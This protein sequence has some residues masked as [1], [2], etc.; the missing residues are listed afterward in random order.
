MAFRVEHGIDFNCAL[1]AFLW[2]NNI[3]RFNVPTNWTDEL[4]ERVAAYPVAELYGS[5]PQTLTGGGRAAK[6]LPAV[7]PNDAAAH[8]ARVRNGGISFDY[9]LNAACFG[10]RETEPAFRKALHGHIQWA[11]DLGVEIIT[12]A[13][14]FLLEFIKTHFPALKVKLSIFTHVTSPAMATI[15]AIRVRCSAAV[16]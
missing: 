5:L 2:H 6:I 4:L 3:M 10:N 7:T 11:Q 16:K 8:I 12:V 9:L 14:P 13:T 15:S 1:A